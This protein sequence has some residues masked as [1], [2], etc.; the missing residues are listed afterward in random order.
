[1]CVDSLPILKLKPSCNWVFLACEHYLQPCSWWYLPDHLI[2]NKCHLFHWRDVCASVDQPCNWRCT[3]FSH[4]ITISWLIQCI[5][6]LQ[7]LLHG[8]SSLINALGSHLLKLATNI[9]SKTTQIIAIDQYIPRG[10]MIGDNTEHQGLASLERMIN[11]R[12]CF[13][14]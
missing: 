6:S 7:S 12:I 13:G 11:K 10:T 4:V 3:D 8:Y 14:E 2:P 5:H 1:M 9:Q